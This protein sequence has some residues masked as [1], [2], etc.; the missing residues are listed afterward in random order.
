MTKCNFFSVIFFKIII[1]PLDKFMS[2]EEMLY[3]AFVTF[4]LIANLL[5]FS[6]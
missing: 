3:V 4:I 5:L 2:Q 6:L 1:L